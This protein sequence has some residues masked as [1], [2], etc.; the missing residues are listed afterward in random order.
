[1][2]GA[3]IIIF[4]QVPPA[5]AVVCAQKSARSIILHLTLKIGHN[6]IISA[7]SAW[8]VCS[9]AR[10]RL[11][12]ASGGP[13][14]ADAIITRNSPS[15]NWSRKKPDCAVG[16]SAAAAFDAVSHFFELGDEAVAMFALNLDLPVFHGAAGA[17]LFL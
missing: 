8:P 16:R 3:P 11:F 15:I 12:S 7:N 9:S 5:L 13:E 10:L 1:M 4:G 17:T 2:S 14:D 6:G